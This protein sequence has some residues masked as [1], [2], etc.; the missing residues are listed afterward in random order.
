VCLPIERSPERGAHAELVL[1]VRIFGGNL[2]DDIQEAVS[3][4]SVKTSAGD[5][6]GGHRDTSTR[7]L[8]VPNLYV[9]L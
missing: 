6:G 2:E 5:G 3:G 9:L 8:P 7:A 1:L 4:R